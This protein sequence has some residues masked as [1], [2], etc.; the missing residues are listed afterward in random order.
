MIKQFKEFFNK[1][2]EFSFKDFIAIIFISMFLYITFRALTSSYSLEVMKTYI[3]I[4]M[5][6]ISFYFGQEVA[7]AYFQSRFPNQYGYNQYGYNQYGY[8][9]YSQYGYPQ[10]QQTNGNIIQQINQK[11]TI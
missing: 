3:P 9:N 1:P 11:P 2:Y 5:V 7:T 10:Y 8:N 4:I 6:I